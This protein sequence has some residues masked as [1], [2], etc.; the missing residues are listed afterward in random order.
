MTWTSK[1]R[2]DQKKERGKEGMAG[3]LMELEK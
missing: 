1:N 3:R 2:I